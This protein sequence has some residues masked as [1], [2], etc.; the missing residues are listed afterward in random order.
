MINVRSLLSGSAVFL[1]LGVVMQPPA[2]LA[3]DAVESWKAPV[4]TT[5]RYNEDWSSLG[6][7]ANRTGRWTEAFK[8]IPL[9]SEGSYLATGGELRLR[10]EG[11]RGNSWGSAA[12]PNDNYLWSRALPYADLHLGAARIFAQPVIAYAAGVDPAPGPVDQT[13]IDLLQAFADVEI[14]LDGETRLR[15]RGG[16]EMIGLGT[17]RLVGTRYG[18]NVPLAFEGGR[19]ILRHR[20]FS[21]SLLY[22]RPVESGPRSMDDRA[23]SSR[24]LWGVYMTQPFGSAGLDFY[25][26][27]YENGEAIFRQGTGDERRHTLGARFFGTEGGWHWNLEAMGQFGRF[28]GGS[29]EALSIATEAGRSFDVLPLKPDLILRFNIASGD[30]SAGDRQL[31]TF[32]ALFP[33]GK[34]FGELSPVGP[35]NLVNLQPAATFDLGHGVSVGLAGAAYWRQ[36]LGDGIYDIPGNLLRAGEGSRSRFIGT[37]AEISVELQA[38]PELT[39]SASLSVFRPGAFVHETGPARTIQMVGLETNF[40][41]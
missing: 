35:Y 10:A 41:F 18:P 23:S 9:G 5:E 14:P 20:S 13:R 31:G 15:L 33:K 25:Y 32:N 6:D 1:G 4:L 8:H 2:L 17:E 12:A 7:P 29:I 36:S 26:L 27:G 28:A 34:Y 19:A 3:T 16:R 37:E 11:Y 39:V 38:T 40:R 22:V 24:R 30:S 21:A